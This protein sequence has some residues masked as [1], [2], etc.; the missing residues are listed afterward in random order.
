MGGYTTNVT[1]EF[2]MLIIKV[3]KMTKDSTWTG[4]SQF[5]V[6]T[7]CRLARGPDLKREAPPLDRCEPPMGRGPMWTASLLYSY[8]IIGNL[9]YS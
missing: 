1:G 8:T 2:R 5:R 7:F 3:K 4:L 6:K 9:F